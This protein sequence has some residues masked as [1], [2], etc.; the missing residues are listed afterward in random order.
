MNTRVV[1]ALGA[2]LI[3][4]APVAAHHSFSAQYDATAM[5]TLKGVV[6]KVDWSNPH[7]H[8]YLDVTDESGSVTTWDLEGSPP[9]PLLRK[10]LTRTVV[11]VGDSITITGFRAR[12]NSSRAS[13]VEVTTGD[14][15]KYDFGG[16]GEFRPLR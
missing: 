2:V 1:Q 15:R 3:A 9:N 8:I 4:A 16:A 6:S 7:V 13:R 11:N 12:D 14:G 10:G 5:V